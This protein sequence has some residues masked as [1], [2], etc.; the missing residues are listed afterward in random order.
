M[1]DGFLLDQKRK[2]LKIAIAVCIMVGS[3][4]L[5]FMLSDVSMLLFM[6]ILI[7]GIVLL[8][9]SYTHL[10]VYKR[11]HLHQCGRPDNP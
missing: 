7:V 4:A 5:S 8:S 6:L 2:Y 1:A 9:V 11:Q 3:L 10:D